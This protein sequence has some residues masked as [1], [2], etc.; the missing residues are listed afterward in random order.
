MNLIWF[1]NGFRKARFALG[2]SLGLVTLA[3]RTANF[4]QHTRFAL[5]RANKHS[6][7]PSYHQHANQRRGGKIKYLKAIE[8]KDQVMSG[9]GL[10]MRL[11]LGC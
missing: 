3:S 8:K 6:Q 2:T 4:G 1:R 10:A 5:V 7:E 9:T 11:I